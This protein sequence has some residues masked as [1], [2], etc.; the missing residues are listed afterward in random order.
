MVSVGWN[1]MTRNS[2]LE[3]D[4]FIEVIYSSAVFSLSATILMTSTPISE[5]QL[6]ASVTKSP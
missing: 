3:N 4:L 5:L 2:S 1:R 6:P